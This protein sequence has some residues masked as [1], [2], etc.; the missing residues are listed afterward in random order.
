MNPFFVEKYD[1]PYEVPP[2]HLIKDEH[3]FPAFREGIKRQQEEIDAIVNN[4][5]SHPLL[6][7]PFWHW[8]TPVNC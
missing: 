5:E 4:P 1:T 6:K 3:Y 7:T 2:F 8:K